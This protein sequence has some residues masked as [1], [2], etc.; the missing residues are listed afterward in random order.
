LSWQDF[1]SSGLE[2][3]FNP[4]AALGPKTSSIIR[5]W[6]V[7]S[8]L[9]RQDLDLIKDIPYGDH[10]LQKFDYCKSSSAKPAII[11]L[12]GGFWRSLDKAVMDWH[13]KQ[14]FE[15]G[16][17][18]YNV[19]YPLCP[20]V[21]LTNLL[22]YLHASLEKILKFNLV[23]EDNP[24]IV[25]MGHSAGAHLAMHLAQSPI[26]QNNLIGII[27]LSGI[28][29]CQVVR[30]ISIN[31]DVCLS[32]NEAENLS[33]LRNLPNNNLSYYI[34]VGAEEPSGWI[35]QSVELYGALNRYDKDVILRVINEA[36]HFSLVDKIVDAKTD[37]GIQLYNWID[38]L[39]RNDECHN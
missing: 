34:A 27:A 29:D 8:V 15:N 26:W 11:L 19:N 33:I 3:Q 30:E 4:R 28:F 5:D 36:N 23:H 7:K 18:V 21:S 17:T 31:E 24:N 1:R 14:L 37:P 12:H 25:L 38:K 22:D 39:S 32:Q 10:V 9:A 13:V 35:D 16:I 6:E 2:N 20:E